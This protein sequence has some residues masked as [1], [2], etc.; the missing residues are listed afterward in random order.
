M[1]LTGIIGIYLQCFK[2]YYTVLYKANQTNKSTS[3]N[4]AM[5]CSSPLADLGGAPSNNRGPM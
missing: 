1:G 5:E 3:R 2:R 4:T